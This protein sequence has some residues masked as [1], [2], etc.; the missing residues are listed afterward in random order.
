MSEHADVDQLGPHEQSAEDVAAGLRTDTGIGLSSPEALARLERAGPNEL[1]TEVAAPA[2]QQF[3]AQFRDALVLLL[4]AAAVISCAV[5]AVERDTNLPYE[6]L[7]I[8]TIVLLNAILGFVQEGRFGTVRLD[9][10]DWARSNVVASSVLWIVETAKFLT[11]RL[12][13]PIARNSV[14][15]GHLLYAVAGGAAPSSV[16]HAA[17]TALGEANC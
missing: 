5:W 7:V 6:G 17:A 10:W 16:G 2:W 9:A 15:P 8:I 12:H 13:P 11:K 3:L 1:E 14:L 4:V